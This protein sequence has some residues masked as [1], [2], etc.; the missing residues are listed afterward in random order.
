M[1]SCFTSMS[2]LLH[3]R[4]SRSNQFFASSERPLVLYVFSM[5][6]RVQDLIIDQISSGAVCVNDTILQYTGESGFQVT[7]L[8][9]FYYLLKISE[10]NREAEIKGGSSIVILSQYFFIV[11]GMPTYDNDI[12][13]ISSKLIIIFLWGKCGK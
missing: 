2:S 6:K 4:T 3:M 12:V 10:K 9:L 11:P 7:A 1:R 8:E 13:H 5:S